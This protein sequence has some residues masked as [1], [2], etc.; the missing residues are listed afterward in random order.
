MTDLLLTLGTN[1][2][3]RSCSV[4]SSCRFRF[5]SRSCAPMV[6]WSARPLEGETVIVGGAGAA[7]L[8]SAIAGA[9]AE[10]GAAIV[11]DDAARLAAVRDACEAHARPARADADTS[12]VHALV[13][14]ATAIE[15]V[16]DSAPR[17]CSF[18]RASLGSQNRAASS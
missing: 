10:A 8:L 4:R 11:V 16:D 1:K 7:P 13:F 2:R 18:S 14:D 5:P 17:I 9:L 12:R 6:P 15:S 3:A